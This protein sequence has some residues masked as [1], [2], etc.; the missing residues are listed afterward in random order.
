MWVAPKERCPECG[1]Q[2]HTPLEDQRQCSKYVDCVDGES[3]K[4]FDKG[5][6]GHHCCYRRGHN[7]DC[8]YVKEL[9]AQ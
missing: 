4:Y 7:G 1:S 8:G 3:C 2:L 9:E 5:E 6:H